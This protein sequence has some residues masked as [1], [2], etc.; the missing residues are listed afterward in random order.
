LV[1]V[2]SGVFKNNTIKVVKISHSAV[3]P[4]RIGPYFLLNWVM[5]KLIDV[6]QMKLAERDCMKMKGIE[7]AELMEAAAKAFT[8]IF[9]CLVPEKSTT[10]LILCGA[11]NNGGDG[12][13]I[14]RLLQ[15]AGY[16]DIEV[17]IVPTSK[18]GTDEF[19]INLRRLSKTPV[20]VKYLSDL[21]G[22]SP[23][24]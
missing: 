6:S 17:N 23:S 19:G 9:C 11:G 8:G 21:T 16:S 14:A 20:V 2:K 22:F 5:I 1:N 12:L 3:N 7:S 10:I 15:Y 4:C 24:Q 13:A 18:P